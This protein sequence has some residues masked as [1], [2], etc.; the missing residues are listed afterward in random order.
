MLKGVGGGGGWLKKWSKGAGK[1]VRNSHAAGR[2]EVDV[3]GKLIR[4]ID[5]SKFL[6][7]LLT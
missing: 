7:G 4:R 5:L 1:L 3:L 6:S 2:G